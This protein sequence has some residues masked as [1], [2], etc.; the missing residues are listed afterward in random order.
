MV[1]FL[2]RKIF[3]VYNG[4]REY[5]IVGEIRLSR[6]LLSMFIGDSFYSFV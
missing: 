4:K 2:S 1:F 6:F 3:V 5:K